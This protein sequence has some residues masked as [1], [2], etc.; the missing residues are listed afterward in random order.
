L[1]FQDFSYDT[2]LIAFYE[3]EIK[4]LNISNYS[5]NFINAIKELKTD[6]PIDFKIFFD[7]A[8][9]YTGAK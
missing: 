4:K 5:D 6:R 8:S 2:I 1:S 9:D 7:A 3:L